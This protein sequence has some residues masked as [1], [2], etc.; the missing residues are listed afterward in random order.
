MNADKEIFDRM[1]REHGGI[2]DIDLIEGP[3]FFEPYIKDGTT[4]F[5]EFNKL[6]PQAP[7]PFLGIIN[8]TSLNACAFRSNNREF[9]GITSGTI[10]LL[11]NLFYWMLCHPDILPSI[12]DVADEV[13]P[14][15]LFNAQITNHD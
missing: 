2:F 9:I 8:N 1:T 12:G 3:S 14:E 13:I 10:P 15:K 4:I 6:Y 11:C 7:I 5:N